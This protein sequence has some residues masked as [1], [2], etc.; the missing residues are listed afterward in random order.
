[1]RYFVD[2]A[3]ENLTIVSFQGSR[4]EVVCPISSIRDIFSL[5]EDGDRAFPR[6]VLVSLAPKERSVLLM[7]VFQGGPKKV[8]QFCMLMESN[9]SRDAFL[10]AMRKLCVASRYATVKAP[11]PPPTP[12]PQAMAQNTPPMLKSLGQERA[13][14]Q[15]LVFVR[16]GADEDAKVFCLDTR[17]KGSQG[18]KD[19]RQVSV[20]FF[21]RSIGV[22]ALQAVSPDGEVEL[23][24]PHLRE[25]VVPYVA[26]FGYTPKTDMAWG[27]SQQTPKA[28]GGPG[29]KPLVTL[30]V[31]EHFE[32]AKHTW[33]VIECSLLLEGPGRVPRLDWLA[34]RRLAHLRGHL[35]SPVKQAS[36]D[37]YPVLF[38]GARFARRSGPPGTTRK[39]HAWCGALADSINSRQA[40]P[41]VAALALVFLEA[42]NPSAG[43]SQATPGMTRAR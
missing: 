10:E 20:Q 28:A 27:H 4:V 40:P 21:M 7:V 11:A 33:Y 38:E 43:G 2:Q 31:R 16:S 15:D 8:T 36:G 41:L 42:P 3:L 29:S 14:E 25:G 9:D 13:E 35:H 19:T 18:K 39:L 30:R 22:Q 26:S 23:L 24:P 12:S 32:A 1:M 5:P 34:P 37:L 6:E 17:E